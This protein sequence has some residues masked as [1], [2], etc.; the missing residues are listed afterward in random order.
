MHPRRRGSYSD[1]SGSTNFCG[2]IILS[3]RFVQL[4]H[5]P[6]KDPLPILDN[7]LK[8][9]FTNPFP[10]LTGRAPWGPS[11]HQRRRL[12]LR[13]AS[14]CPSTSFSCRAPRCSFACSLGATGAP[15]RA[16]HPVVP[17]GLL[18]CRSSGTFGRK[19][20]A[21][22]GPKNREGVIQK[23]DL[24]MHVV[25]GICC[26]LDPMLLFWGSSSRIN[27]RPIEAGVSSKCLDLQS[28][29]CNLRSCSQ[30]ARQP[31]RNLGEAA[32]SQPQLSHQPYSCQGKV[33]RV[34]LR[35]FAES[36]FFGYSTGPRTQCPAKAKAL[37]ERRSSNGAQ[38]R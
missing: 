34:W 3:L 4:E 30:T 28:R 15:H 7:C 18:A 24:R 12:L 19:S 11:P 26:M 22:W 8:L 20:T 29:V 31:S 36:G 23:Q 32:A 25:Q 6:R 16:A 10:L 27:I 14:F 21:R 9:S 33:L 17:R 13:P 1:Y 5:A 37:P 35:H 2:L 38:V